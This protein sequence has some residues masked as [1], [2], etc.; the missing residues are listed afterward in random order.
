[1]TC[2]FCA[3]QILLLTLFAMLLVLWNTDVVRRHCSRSPNLRHPSAADSRLT[4]Q[5]QP[6]SIGDSPLADNVLPRIR[7]EQ[8]HRFH[9][10]LVSTS[11]VS[12]SS[13]RTRPAWQY[14]IVASCLQ[15]TRQLHYL[16]LR[17]HVSLLSI[18]TM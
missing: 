6:S 14:V 11:A 9:D 10:D 18:V 16:F 2:V 4:N 5:R 12:S 3:L 13:A 1:M 8:Q 17:R 7:K 15:L